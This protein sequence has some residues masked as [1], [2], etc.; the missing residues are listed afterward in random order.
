MGHLCYSTSSTPEWSKKAI[1]YQIMVDR[2][3]NGDSSIHTPNFIS[4]DSPPDYFNNF[5][6]DLPGIKQKIP[7]LKKLFH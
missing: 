7:Y 5:G 4:W 2:F 6:G 1:W 3:Y